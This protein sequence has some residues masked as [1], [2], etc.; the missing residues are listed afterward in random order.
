M[1]RSLI[2]VAAASAFVLAS[3]F[4]IAATSFAPA[5]AS[6]AAMFIHP[7]STATGATGAPIIYAVNSGTG[8]GVRGDSAMGKG[9]IGVTTGKASSLASGLAGVNGQDL[10]TGTQFNAGVRGF[11]SGGIGVYGIANSGPGV[12]GNSTN[13]LGVHGVSTNGAGVEGDGTVG[14][15]GKGSGTYGV[16]G[17]ETN[18]IGV[19]GTSSGS[20]GVNGGSTNS[21]G[22]VGSTTAGPAGMLG[23]NGATQGTAGV[24]GLTQLAS[25]GIG[26]LGSDSSTAAGGGFGVD[27]TSTNGV[28]LAVSNFTDSQYAL[29]IAGGSPQGNAANTLYLLAAYYN[30]FQPGARGCVSGGRQQNVRLMAL[31]DQGDLHLCGIVFANDLETEGLCNVGCSPATNT[32]EGHAVRRYAPTQSEPSVDDFGEATLENGAAY[33]RLDPSFANVIDRGATYLVFITPE[34]DS[35]GLYVTNK[36]ASGFAVKENQGGR[37]TLA[38]SYRIVAK[39]FGQSQPRLPMV[40][41]PAMRAPAMPVRRA[42]PHVIPPPNEQTP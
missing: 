3:I 13:G 28:G 41:T 7:N 12:L 39:P 40:L 10:A 30:G 2:Q 6:I 20:Y 9:V 4:F 32:N 27:A 35:K 8:A 21:Y 16:L 14:I 25:G 23:E 26:V 37:S 22:V 1:T 33:V 11:S 36:S 15:L 24:E 18:G 31:D 42:V 19:A 29:T 34:G 17:Q 5:H 38:F